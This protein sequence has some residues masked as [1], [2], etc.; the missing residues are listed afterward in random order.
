M[1]TSKSEIKKTVD[2]SLTQALKNL[3]VDPKGKVARAVSKL[4]KALRKKLESDI[5]KQAKKTKPK[6]TAS[7]NKVKKGV[8]E[9]DETQNG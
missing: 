7:K 8:V 4:A 3:H 6:A 9:K 1:K 5:K 2:K